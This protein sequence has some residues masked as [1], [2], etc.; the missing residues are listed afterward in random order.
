[1]VPVVGLEPTSLAASDLKSDAY[2][3]SATPAMEARVGVA[4]THGGFADRSVTTS[5]TRLVKSPA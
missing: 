3:N 5:P 4:P 1:M 2:A